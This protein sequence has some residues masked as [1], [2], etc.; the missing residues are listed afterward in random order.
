MTVRRIDSSSSSI[1]GAPTADH[2]LES[3]G[4]G[5]WPGGSAAQSPAKPAMIPAS[6]ARQPAAAVA[7][8]TLHAETVAEGRSASGEDGAASQASASAPAVPETK[9]QAVD[10][11]DEILR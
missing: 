3:V 2:T 11:F 9:Q 7:I 1:Y 8:P 6:P 4:L 10:I 5:S